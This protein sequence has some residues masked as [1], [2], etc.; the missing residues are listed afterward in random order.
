MRAEREAS[1]PCGQGTYHTYIHIRIYV[2]IYIHVYV[3]IRIYM[4]V[5]VS[6]CE[7]RR[8]AEIV[9]SMELCVGMVCM[10]RLVV[11]GELRG[12]P[13]DVSSMLVANLATPLGA[14]PLATLRGS[15]VM[16]IDL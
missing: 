1:L 10:D 5:S 3:C 6:V 16:T 8:G 9:T 4:C 11:E 15:D 12:V 13:A 14:V 7:E 2:Y